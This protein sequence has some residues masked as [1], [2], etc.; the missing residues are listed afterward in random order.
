MQ[1][2]SPGQ[3]ESLEEDMATHSGIRAQRIP[4]TEEPGGLQSM[5]SDTTDVTEHARVHNLSVNVSAM[6]EVTVPQRHVH[7]HIMGIA[8]NQNFRK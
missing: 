5:G 6:S 4:W 2:Q 3:E 1:V 8:H 7:F